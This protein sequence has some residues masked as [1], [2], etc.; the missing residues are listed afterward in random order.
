M[1]TLEQS[2]NNF[3]KELRESLESASSHKQIELIRI[4]FLGRK[5]KINEIMGQMK[6]L[7]IEEI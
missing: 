6:S 2:I 4:D 3:E 5:G 7:D 1:K